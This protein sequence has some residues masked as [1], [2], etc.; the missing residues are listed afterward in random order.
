MQDLI[1]AQKA[2]QEQSSGDDVLSSDSLTL[3]SEMG[4]PK[5]WCEKAMKVGIRTVLVQTR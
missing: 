4:F 3:L 5:S 1:D 2:E